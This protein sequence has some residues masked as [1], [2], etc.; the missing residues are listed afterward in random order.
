[1]TF[2]AEAERVASELWRQM[3]RRIL[4]L[5]LVLSELR[6]LS[7]VIGR[8]IKFLVTLLVIT[9]EEASWPPTVAPSVHLVS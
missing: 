6:L 1:M 3:E 4:I 2:W 7:E 9:L 5:I 8:V